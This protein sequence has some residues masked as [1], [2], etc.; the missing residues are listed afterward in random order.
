MPMVRMLQVML[1]LTMPLVM[2]MVRAPQVMVLGVGPHVCG[3]LLVLGVGRRPS[4]RS[5]WRALL[6]VFVTPSI[7]VAPRQSWRMLVMLLAR[8]LQVM[9][10]ARAFS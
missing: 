8:M 2:M 6:A 10:M 4:W 7:R 1:R 5:A 9:P 3:R